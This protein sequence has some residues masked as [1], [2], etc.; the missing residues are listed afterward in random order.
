MINSIISSAYGYRKKVNGATSWSR[1]NYGHFLCLPPQKQR[2]FH[3]GAL[4]PTQ[5]KD[6]LLHENIVYWLTSLSVAGAVSQITD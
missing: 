6:R 5:L 4:A 2:V 1:A 3:H